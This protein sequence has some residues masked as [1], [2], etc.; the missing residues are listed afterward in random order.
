MRFIP[1]RLL[2]KADLASNSEGGFM[3]HRELVTNLDANVISSE[4][5]DGRH[6][7]VLDID[8]PIYVIPSST[9]GNF[10]LYIEKGLS[11]DQYS[12]LLIALADAGI[13]Q[14]GYLGACL[15]RRA[16]YVRLPWVTKTERDG[17]F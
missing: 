4:A 13:I 8:F 3:P 12:K 10:H 7:P 2:Y 14:E 6:Y 5:E 11:W 16:T 17:R 15:E 1:K 9:P